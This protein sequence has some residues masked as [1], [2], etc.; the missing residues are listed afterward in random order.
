MEQKFDAIVIV[1]VSLG[2]GLALG[3]QL[4][5]GHVPLEIVQ[6]IATLALGAW[7]ALVV[8]DLFVHVASNAI[9]N[10][11]NYEPEATGDELTGERGELTVF[12]A[13]NGEVIGEVKSWHVMPDRKRRGALTER[14]HRMLVKR[15]ERR[16]QA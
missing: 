13:R 16:P 1:P 2:I 3:L 15:S 6:Q 14:L 10:A 9:L 12:L 7:I 4:S 8:V 5:I 11:V